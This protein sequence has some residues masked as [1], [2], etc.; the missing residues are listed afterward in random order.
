MILS[1]GDGPN[2]EVS[3]ER[4]SPSFFRKETCLALAKVQGATLIWFGSHSPREAA[5]RCVPMWVDCPESIQSKYFAT[6]YMYRII[7]AEGLARPNTNG[8]PPAH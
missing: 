2:I 1:V 6:H 3:S 8:H 5:E 4:I 7:S